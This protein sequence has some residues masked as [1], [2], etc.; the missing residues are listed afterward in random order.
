M[1]IAAA[2][3]QWNLHRRIALG[4]MATDRHR[5]APAPRR[6]P[7]GHRLHLALDL[8]HRD[9]DDDDADRPR[10]HRA[11]RGARA[12]AGCATTA[13][14]SCW[15][16]PTARTS[17]ASA[18]RSARRPTASSPASSSAWASRS[19]F[20]EFLLV[21]LPFV[22]AAA[23]ARLVRCSGA[24]GARTGLAGDAREVVRARARGARRRCSGRSGSWPA[25]SSPPPPSGSRA[26]RSS[27]RSQ[28]SLPAFKLGSAHVEGGDRDGRGPAAPLL[29]LSRPAG[30]RAARA[31]ERCRGRRCC[32]W[33]AASRWRRASSRAGSRP[34]WAPSSPAIATLPPLAPDRPRGARDRRALGGR[35]EHGDDRRHAAG[36]Q[37][38]GRARRC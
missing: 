11:A 32:S 35:L 25:S 5:S 2:M 37:G 24:S 1:A 36:A 10:A 14:R 6:R 31:R 16:S 12:A 33:A 8:Q 3:Q 27:T 9:R 19:R 23:A 34:G 26:S 13:W 21:G 22:L 30:P 17:A 18:P 38:R 7:R 20:L 29:A 15:R 28:P 4:I